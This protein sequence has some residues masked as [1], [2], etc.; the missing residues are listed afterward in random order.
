MFSSGTPKE[1]TN[2]LCYILKGSHYA[3]Q[4]HRLSIQDVLT[5]RD[6]LKTCGAGWALYA[7]MRADSVLSPA[8]AAKPPC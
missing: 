5:I 8:V 3:E 4:Q 2:T 7:F 6:S 1:F